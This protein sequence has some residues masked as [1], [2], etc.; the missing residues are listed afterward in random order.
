MFI[1]QIAQTIILRTEQTK[2]RTPLILK[3]SLENSCV[4]LSRFF[5]LPP[6]LPNLKPASEFKEEPDYYEAGG[7]HRV[8]LG[9]SFHHDRDTVL[10]KLGYSQ[11]FTV[12]LV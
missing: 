10:R 11:Y 8:S 5:L 6:Q 12:W 1:R 7:F 4:W 9:D 3:T 2:T